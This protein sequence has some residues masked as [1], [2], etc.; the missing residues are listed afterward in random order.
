MKKLPNGR[1]E[2]SAII[3]LS[4]GGV[5]LVVGFVINVLV[6]QSVYSKVGDCAPNVTTCNVDK[7]QTLAHIGS[8]LIYG[9]LILLVIGAIM[10]IVASRNQKKKK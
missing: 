10:L 9:A 4:L 8:T 7:E 3:T 6:L 1:S 2:R 5:M